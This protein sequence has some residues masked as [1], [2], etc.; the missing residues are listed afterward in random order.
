MFTFLF[1]LLGNLTKLP[2]MEFCLGE[3]PAGFC[4]VACCCC[5]SS[6]QV[7]TFPAYF[8]LPPALH[9][10]FSGQWRCPPSLSSTLATF[11]LLYLCQVFSSQFYCKCYDFEWVIFTHRR[12]L[13]YAP[14]LTFLTQPAFIKTSLGAGS[15]SLKFAGLHT[16]PRNIDPAHLFVWFTVIHKLHIQNDSVLNS[17]IY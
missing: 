4:D 1:M 17:T 9:L 11:Q 13:H 14:S 8:S 16:D 6:L 2:E 3:P 12:F 10:G 15:F 7:F 5:F